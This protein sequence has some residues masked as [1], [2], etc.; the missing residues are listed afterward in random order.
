MQGLTLN[1]SRSEAIRTR[2]VIRNALIK[3][4]QSGIRK[5]T[6]WNV[7]VVMKEPGHPSGK[8][9]SQSRRSNRRKKKV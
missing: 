5:K 2:T 7:K 3:V 4:V 1:Y 8:I 6:E 9:Q